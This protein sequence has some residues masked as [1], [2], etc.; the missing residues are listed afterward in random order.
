MIIEMLVSQLLQPLAL[1]PLV[2]F[3]FWTMSYFQTHYAEPS[4]RLTLE[5]AKELDDLFA[6]IERSSSAAEQR[7][8]PKNRFTSDHYKQPVLTQKRSLPLFYRSGLEDPMTL[9][10]RNQ[11]NSGDRTTMWYANQENVVDNIIV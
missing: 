3:S 6:K 2:Y 4:K 10:V 7:Q 11:L 1:V 5:R 8:I 9:Q